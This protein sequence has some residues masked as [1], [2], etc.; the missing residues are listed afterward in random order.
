MVIHGYPSKEYS[1]RH[2][3]LQKIDRAW[4]D[5]HHWLQREVSTRKADLMN[6]IKHTG[7]DSVD[8]ET[9][10][11]GKLIKASLENPD[12]G[13]S[14]VVGNLFIFFFAGVSTIP[15]PTRSAW[16]TG[17]S[18]ST[19]PQRGRWPTLLHSLPWI[20][21]NKRKFISI[22][23]RQSAIENRYVVRFLVNPVLNFCPPSFLVSY[24]F[25]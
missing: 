20:R 12:F 15:S 10:V 24:G 7:N 11:F 5:L 21:T 19:K 14:E 17:S 22:S 2:N 23:F 18:R 3:S 16:L 8:H 25:Q 13:D 4:R 1:S 6:V 9:N